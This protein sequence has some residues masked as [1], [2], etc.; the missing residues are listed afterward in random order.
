[1][2]IVTLVDLVMFNSLMLFY[3]KCFNIANLWGLNVFAISRALFSLPAS[4]SDLEQ[5]IVA[6]LGWTSSNVAVLSDVSR[7]ATLC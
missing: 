3:C 6:R 7:S 1:M 2:F 4:F 5:A